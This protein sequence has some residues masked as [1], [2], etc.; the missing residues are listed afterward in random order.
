MLK[1]YSI[2]LDR[3]W[4][5]Q[6]ILLQTGEQ[7]TAEQ[8][9]L[10]ET[11]FG[12][13]KEKILALDPNPMFLLDT[14]ILEKGPL[15]NGLQTWI[16]GWY[17]IW[18]TTER[19]VTE[20]APRLIGATVDRGHNEA[21]GWDRM[22][23]N[24][25]WAGMASLAGNRWN[26]GDLNGTPSEVTYL[27]PNFPEIRE[28]VRIAEAQGTLD[29]EF[30]KSLRVRLDADETMEVK[31]FKDE[32]SW[33]VDFVREGGVKGA[34]AKRAV[35][36]NH[37]EGDGA[38]LT[39]NSNEEMLAHPDVKKMIGERVE[40]EMGNPDRMKR[41][42]LSAPI[43]MVRERTDVKPLLERPT[44]EEVL[45]SL[46]TGEIEI[47]LAGSMDLRTAATAKIEGLRKETEVFRGK[48]REILLEEI[49]D[50][51]TV[52]ITLA[53]HDFSHQDEEKVRALGR[54]VRAKLTGTAN[55]G[56]TSSGQGATP[57]KAGEIKLGYTPPKSAE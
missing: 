30:C 44:R 50:E 35:M 20:M 43:E 39:F 21:G 23:G 10:L 6:G 36:L 57:E 51:T 2:A 37:N 22:V 42:V 33:G 4:Q 1:S 32:K 16:F 11:F 34:G 45:K 18:L 17:G 14:N 15:K 28:A 52:N 26:L 55:P 47:A 13:R 9:A 40:A 41:I 24:V 19:F 49:E 53:G 48:A 8:E 12:G 5:G 38:M 31:K 56:V 29:R 25:V 7:R 46:T 27:K 54:T 3:P